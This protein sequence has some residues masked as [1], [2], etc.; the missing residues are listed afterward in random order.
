MSGRDGA[1][2]LGRDLSGLTRAE[3][4]GDRDAGPRFAAF[5]AGEPRREGEVLALRGEIVQR[6][7]ERGACARRLLVLRIDA[8][9]EGI[10]A[11][12]RAGRCSRPYMVCLSGVKTI[13]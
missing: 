10:E 12:L 9:E 3:Q 5:G 11:R 2:R 13:M 1:S 4:R 6:R 7:V 8:I